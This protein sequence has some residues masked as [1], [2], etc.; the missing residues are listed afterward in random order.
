MRKPKP[1]TKTCKHCMTEI[2]YEA[3]VC[4]QCRKKQKGSKLNIIIIAILIIAVIGTISGGEDTINTDAYA[5]SEKEYKA[6]CEKADYEGLA[7][8]P[9]DYQDKKVKMTGQIVQV[10]HDSNSSNSTYLIAITKD[11]FGF[12]S[13]NIFVTMKADFKKTK[14]LEEDIVAIYGAGR[15]EYTYKSVLG[16]SI[17]VPSIEAIYMDIKKDK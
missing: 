2:P 7:R 3:K 6:A 17:T 12:Y 4:P 1:E 16:Q 11:E 9:D 15:G 13:D 5:L 14:Y 8:T 10:V